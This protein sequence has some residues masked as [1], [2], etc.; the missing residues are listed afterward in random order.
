MLLIMLVFALLAGCGVAVAGVRHSF[1]EAKDRRDLSELTLSSPWSRDQLLLPDQLPA[2]G[3]MGEVGSGGLSLTYP[4]DGTAASRLI[5]YRI[6]VLD[7]HGEPLW[8]VSCTAYAV[9][10]CTELGD[11]YTLVRE[12]DT[13]N[14]DPA[15]SVRRRVGDRQFAA[16]VLGDHSED[17]PLLRSLVTHTHRPTDAELLR[18][19]R[20]RGYR[21][22]WS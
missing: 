14:S 7:E 18:I 21:T 6:E 3:A 11:G 16:R 22:D 17:V 13:G 8:D 10:V 15:T 20:P 12:L 5:E 9:V 4:L 19:L 2:T 1:A